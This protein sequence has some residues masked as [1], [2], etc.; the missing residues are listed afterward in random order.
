MTN[1]INQGLSQGVSQYQTN[2]LINSI[3]GANPNPY[4][5]G[6]PMTSADY[7]QINSYFKS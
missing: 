7:G 6:S 1:A 4:S 5:G 3:R 2:S